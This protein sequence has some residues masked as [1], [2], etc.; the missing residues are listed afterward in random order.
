MKYTVIITK[1]EKSFGAH[2]PDLPG[3]VASAKTYA[4]VLKLI[5]EAIEEH[6]HILRA[7]GKSEPTQCSSAINASDDKF[8]EWS[9]REPWVAVDP[10]FKREWLLPEP[11]RYYLD[12]DK[13]TNES[14]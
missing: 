12:H 10:Q 3:C 13:D 5:E 4:K 7:E 14:S 8:D 1:G 9:K 6:L 2:V 11:L